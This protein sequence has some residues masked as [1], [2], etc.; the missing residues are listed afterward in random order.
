M[1]ASAQWHLAAW[2]RGPLWL[3]HQAPFRVPESPLTGNGSG[4]GFGEMP[5]LSRMAE[6][7]ECGALSQAGCGTFAITTIT[8]HHH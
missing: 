7:E 2:A 8:R 4:L 5:V 3:G 1:S 6:V